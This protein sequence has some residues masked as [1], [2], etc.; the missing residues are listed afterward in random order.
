MSR[1]E[2][3][4]LIRDVPAAIIDALD[5]VMA[6]QG[7]RRVV[8]RELR[9]DWSPLL[10]ESGGPTMLVLSQPRDDWTACFSSLSFAAEWELSEAIAAGLEQPT[11]YALISDDTAAYAY[12]YFEDGVL[13][14]EVSPDGDDSARLD[15]DALIERLLTHGIAPELIDDR[16]LNFGA[17]HIL[18]GYARA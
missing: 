14:E 3:L 6:T 2:K 15:S 13:R 7:L 12:R 11:V 10:A 4:I 1:D 17:A 9:E 16:T 5:G 18:V 8:T